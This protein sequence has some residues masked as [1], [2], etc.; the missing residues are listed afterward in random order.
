LFASDWE[1]DF[2]GISVPVFIWH[3]TDDRNVPLAHALLM[4]EAIPNSVLETFDG[5][6]HFYFVDRLEEILIALKP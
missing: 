2:G 3:G 1:F 6:G 4:H 5:E